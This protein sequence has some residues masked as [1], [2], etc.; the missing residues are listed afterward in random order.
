MPRRKTATD[1]DAAPQPTQD[2]PQEIPPTYPATSPSELLAEEGAPAGEKKRPA[3]K[4]GPIP[5]GKGESV[6]GCVWENVVESDGRT[7]N[8]HNIVLTVEY[9][10]Q[11]E[12]RWKPS[13]GIR[14]S[15]LATVEYVL[16]KCGDFAFSRR[17]PQSEVPF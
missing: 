12:D 4:V 7:Y 8:V 5:T 17:D 10:D 11:K 14:P 16:R 3:F 6:S 2:A 9:F 13:H 15:Q 1:T